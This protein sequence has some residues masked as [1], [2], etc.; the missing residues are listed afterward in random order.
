MV[1]IKKGDKF[2][3]AG[4]HKLPDGS[5]RLGKK[6]KRNRADKT[7]DL[8]VTDI[9]T[10]T[11]DEESELEKLVRKYNEAAMASIE[12]Y[13]HMAKHHTEDNPED[14]VVK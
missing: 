14:E 11:T 13:S 9:V 7:P 5:L 6:H 12:F 1:D 4:L 3:I 8:I 10:N 2:T